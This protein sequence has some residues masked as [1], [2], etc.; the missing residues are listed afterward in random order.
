MQ[1]P[2]DGVG[3]QGGMIYC[4]GYQRRR[5]QHRARRVQSVDD[6]TNFVGNGCRCGCRT[7]G[8]WDGAA[9]PGARPV[10]NL[11]ALGQRRGQRDQELYGEGPE[12]FKGHG[13]ES[14]QADG[15]KWRRGERLATLMHVV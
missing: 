1:A 4:R 12:G 9:V 6:V 14:L 7:G 11:A 15:L 13:R 8:A 10:A 5:D 2:G 3:G